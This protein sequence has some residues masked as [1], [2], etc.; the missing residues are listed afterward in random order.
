MAKTFH[1]S[2]APGII[3]GGF[4]VDLAVRNLP[5]RIL[6]DAVCETKACLPDAIQLLTPCTIGNG[7]LKVIHLGRFAL[8]LYNKEDRKGVRVFVSTEKVRRW[9][10]IN[11]WFFK[12]KPK[13][14]QDHGM[15]IREIERSAGDILDLQH[16]RVHEEIAQKSHKGGIA[17][18]PKCGEA[19]PVDDG[20]SCLACGGSLLY[21]KY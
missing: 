2:E 10:E 13:M 16:V 15:I 12:L 1:G 18:C 20:A 17:V 21:E 14:E 6:Y 3:I 9:P 8:S 19:Y 7:W 11:G 4:M 5:A